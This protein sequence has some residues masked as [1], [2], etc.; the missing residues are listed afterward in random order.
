MTFLKPGLSDFIDI[1]II[2]LVIYKMFTIVSKNGGTQILFVVGILFVLYISSTFLNLKMMAGFLKLLKDYWIL[3][4]LILFQPEIRNFLLRFGRTEDLSSLFRR[5]TKFRYSSLLEA[6]STMSFNKTG[7]LIL[8]EN[9][10]KLDNFIATGEIIDSNLSS[11]L[12][13]TIFNNKTIL[14][15]GAIIIRDHRVHAVKVILPH[16]NNLEYK[17][18]F[19]TRHLAAIGATEI[20][21][22]FA[23]IVS[24]ETGR[25]STAQNGEIYTNVSTEELAQRIPDATRI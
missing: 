15:D 18:K 13:L 21:D 19:G 20:T 4:L 1:L 6:I 11:K 16:T 12:L 14:H 5:R 17:Q 2:A 10:Q 24:E 8:I 9:K 23:I 7:A 22:A 3:A 25:I